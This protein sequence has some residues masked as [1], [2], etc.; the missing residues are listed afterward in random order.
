M[1]QVDPADLVEMADRS[2]VEVE[3]DDVDSMEMVFCKLHLE[4]LER[5]LELAPAFES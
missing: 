2:T 5:E 3:A 1:G 4:V